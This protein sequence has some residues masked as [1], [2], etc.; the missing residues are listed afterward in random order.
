M[1]E[2]EKFSIRKRI[3][4]FRYAFDGLCLLFREEH[5]ARIHALAA[6]VVVVLGFL[7]DIKAV[8]W[9][10]LV[11]CIAL[12][13]SAEI[14]NSALERVADFI[15]VERDDRKRDIKDLGAAAVLVCAIGAAVVGLIVFVPYIW[16]WG[17]SCM[18][19]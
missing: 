3:R 4:S 14:V 2:K 5:N 19:R 11:V 1:K 10:A 17:V 15:K 9:I 16:M 6:L 12:V 8:E 7:F 18:G 13:V